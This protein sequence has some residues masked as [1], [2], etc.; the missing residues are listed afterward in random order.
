MS[1]FC[2]WC[3]NPS[4]GKGS[5]EHIIPKAIGCPDG[6]ELKNGEVCRNCNNGLG[7]LDQAVVA[8]FE[9]PALIAGVP[10]GRLKG[11]EIHSFGNTFAHQHA[12]RGTE[13]FINMDPKPITLE[14][15]LTLGGFKGRER[16]LRWKLTVDG[17]QATASSGFEFGR[18]PKVARALYKI[19][20]SWVAYSCGAKVARNLIC[21]DIGAF[22]KKGYPVRPVFMF[23]EADSNQYRHQFSN[24][25]EKSS[26]LVATTFRLGHSR[27][28]IDLT[29][30]LSF[31]AEWYAATLSLHGEHGW[32]TLP[33]SWEPERL[34]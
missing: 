18:S 30:D 21:S 12:L 23:S 19:G 11:P 6:F 1:A 22:V 9:V 26:R 34:S 25:I 16:D 28:F 32:T 20:L 4:V 5:I 10:R 31:S 14:N 3:G 24:H 17:K 15:G 33:P 7:H 2:I 29:S 13:I 27:F 8:D